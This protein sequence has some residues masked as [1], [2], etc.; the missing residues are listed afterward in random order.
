MYVQTV[1]DFLRGKLAERRVTLASISREYGISL[2]YISTMLAGKCPLP[3]DIYV[4]IC[5]KIGEDP[6]RLKKKFI[7]DFDELP[8]CY[9]SISAKGWRPRDLRAVAEFER[10][11]QE[12]AEKG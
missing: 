4:S 7:L 8:H 3:W 12:Q 6:E 11:H 1:T 2:A 10:K 5:E 9:P